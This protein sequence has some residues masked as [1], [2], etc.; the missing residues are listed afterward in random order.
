MTNRVRGAAI[1]ALVCIAW[2]GCGAQSLGSESTDE[3]T[4]PNGPAADPG[5][6]ERA[7]LVSMRIEVDAIRASATA[8]R[9]ALE[10][11][12]GVVQESAVDEERAH[13]ELRVPIA[14]LDQTCN[15]LGALGRVLETRQ[16]EEDVT[17]VHADQQA[18][19]VSAHAEETRL[20]A[21]FADRTAALAD[22]LAVEHEL[23]RVRGEIEHLDA[24]ERVLRDR[25]AMARVSLDLVRRAPAFT[26][27]PVAFVESAAGAGL[28][29]TGALLLATAATLAFLAPAA[30]ILCALGAG[31]A[32]V[33]RFLRT[34]AMT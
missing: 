8:V 13:L 9:A 3:S 28:R 22:V 34:R 25:I 10:D 31:L 14:R 27:E 29:F 2:V 11:A 6:R 23:T 26:S 21:M 19:L 32:L 18:R 16:T 33:R 15:A 4:R 20:L 17:F 1:A 5:V 30:S 12:D 7:V 24:D